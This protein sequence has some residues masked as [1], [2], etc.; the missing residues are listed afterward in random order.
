MQRA[1]PDAVRSLVDVLPTLRAQE[2]LIVGEGTAVPVRVRFS[3]LSE[4]RRPHSADVSFAA[5]W[6]ENTASADYVADIV[7][8]WRHQERSAPGN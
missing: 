2:A 6:K 7:K 8:R 1:L 5:L 3:D 4:D